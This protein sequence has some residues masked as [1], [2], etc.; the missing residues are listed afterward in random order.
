[1]KAWQ[2]YKDRNQCCRHSPLLM[3]YQI[4]TYAA[5]AAIFET[6]F[7]FVTK[8]LP[9]SAVP[10]Q[11]SKGLR[12]AVKRSEVEING[13]KKEDR[14]HRL[15]ASHVPVPDRKAHDCRNVV[16]AKRS[17]PQGLSEQG[18]TREETRWLLLESCFLNHILV[19]LTCLCRQN[20]YQ[21]SPA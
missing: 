18:E 20:V 12:Q 8:P 9:L 10:S 4:L 13:A 1:M 3:S 11:P 14:R 21:H 19:A 7:I 15:L 16:G 2:R 5:P 17:V 6:A